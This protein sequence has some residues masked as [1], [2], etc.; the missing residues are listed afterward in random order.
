MTQYFFSLFLCF[1]AVRKNYQNH[2]QN[3][4]YCRLLL[5]R[6]QCKEDSPPHFSSLLRSRPGCPC[7]LALSS[8]AATGHEE[9]MSFSPRKICSQPFIS[10]L[11]ASRETF[12]TAAQS[13]CELLPKR[14]KFAPTPPSSPRGR[15]HS[16][17]IR[18]SCCATT[19]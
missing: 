18:C 11:L 13:A 8:T 9:L 12:H 10:L 7:H 17:C 19:A 16:L 3:L 2:E 5:D 4:S 14:G 6:Q 1:E 15:H